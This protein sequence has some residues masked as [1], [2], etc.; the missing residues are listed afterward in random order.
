M[1]AVEHHRR[2]PP[3]PAAASVGDGAAPVRRC[4]RLDRDVGLCGPGRATHRGRGGAARDD[5]H[6]R[7][8]RAAHRGR[9][10]GGDQRATVWRVCVDPGALREHPQRQVPSKLACAFSEDGGVLDDTTDP[11][12]A[13][14]L[15][16][17]GDGRRIVELPLAQWG[18]LIFVNVTITEPARRCRSRTRPRWRRTGWW[19]PGSG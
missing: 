15:G 17:V 10:D 16:F 1:S 11:T 7:C 3:Q 12:G 2:G 18:P 6:P 5:R 9:S 8:A 14:R 19:R 4:H 13:G